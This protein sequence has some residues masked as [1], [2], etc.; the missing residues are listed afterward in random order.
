M[1]RNYSAVKTQIINLVRDHEDVI[2]ETHQ[3]TN[4]NDEQKID[5]LQELFHLATDKDNAERQQYVNLL[6]ENMMGRLMNEF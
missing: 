5:A 6:D 1:E 4:M 3:L 2:S